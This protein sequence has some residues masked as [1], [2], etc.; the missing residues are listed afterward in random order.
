MTETTP[1]HTTNL[2]ATYTAFAGTSRLATAPLAE[3]ALAVKRALAAQADATILIYDDRTGRPID[4]DLRGSDAELSAR[5]AAPAEEL[6]GEPRGRGRPKLGVVAREVT[7]LPRHWD[8]LATQQGGA[9]V[10]LRR[11]VEEARGKGGARQ[12]RRAAQDAAYHFMSAMAGD[13]PGF[14]E[15]IRAL[16]ADDRAALAARME[17]W[18]PDIRDHAMKLADA[19]H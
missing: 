11:L 4:L 16:Y 19:G 14:E 1:E 5:Y 17:S 9:S 18:P 3:V 10:A 7:L 13:L 12:R 15:A 6:T 8:W 2:P